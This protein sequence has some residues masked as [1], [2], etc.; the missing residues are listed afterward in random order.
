MGTGLLH[1]VNGVLT[2]SSAPST[3]PLA[4]ISLA[5]AILSEGT[6][7]N[8]LVKNIPFTNSISYSLKLTYFMPNLAL[9]QMN[10]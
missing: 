2:I 3:L 7:L 10:F 8:F 1:I 6:L 5:V 4:D 9:E